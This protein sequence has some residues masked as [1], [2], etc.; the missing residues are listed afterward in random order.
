[1]RLQGDWSSDVCSSDL[2]APVVRRHVL[3]F[4]VAEDRVEPA[5]ARAGHVLGAKDRAVVALEVLDALLDPIERVVTVEADHV[6]LVEL[7][8]SEERR[9]GKEGRSWRG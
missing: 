7:H 6:A 9:V 1:T 8:R 5:A 2:E 4:E 3:L